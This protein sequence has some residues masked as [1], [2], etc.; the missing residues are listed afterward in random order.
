MRSPVLSSATP[1]GRTVV[2]EVTDDNVVQGLGPPAFSLQQEGLFVVQADGS[3]LRRLGPASREPPFRLVP[4]EFP[5]GFTIPGWPLFNFGPNGRFAVFADRGPG[6]DGSDAAQAVLLDLETGERTQLTAFVASSQ[7]IPRGDDVGGYFLDDD[8]IAAYATEPIT[9]LPLFYSV[10]KDG[11]GLEPILVTI[12]IPGA[13]VSPTF[14]V[15]AG[16]RTVQN[17]VLPRQATEPRPERV[18]EMFAVD[19]TNLLQVTNFGRS[20][21]VGGVAGPGRRRVFFRASADPFGRNPS[22]ACQLFSI[23]VLGD[24][25]RQLT[26]FASGA[27]TDGCFTFPPPSC[28][29][30]GVI[31]FDPV[32]QALVFEETCDSFGLNPVGS[33]IV[34]M[35]PDGSGFRQ[36]TNYRGMTTEPDG[37]VRVELPGPVD[38][39]GRRK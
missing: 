18:A 9:G 1:N 39:S 12:P 11:T 38:Y 32:T 26:R 28:G 36:L 34:A 10:R 4:S 29:A 31:L 3:G 37:T 21:T 8:T 23:G 30:S 25:L 5:P 17:I 16:A 20:D 6:A 24:G 13:E 27:P 35:H 14:Q 15:A 2:F 7:G 22:H 19:G 33:Q